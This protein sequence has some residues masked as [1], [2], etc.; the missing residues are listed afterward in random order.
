MLRVKLRKADR[1]FTELVRQ[2]YNY[3]C[4]K[5]GRIYIPDVHNLANLGV[6]HYFSRRKEATRFDLDNVTLL[7]N[8]PCHRLWETEN[9]A[10]YKEHMINRLGQ[11]GFDLLEYRSH[12]YL[13][14][15]DKMVELYLKEKLR[16][17]DD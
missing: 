2:I 14:R 17:N 5:C 10:E 12:T 3:T 15:D 8:F 6:S 11:E 1:L 9:R 4:Q 7:C 13:K 16:R